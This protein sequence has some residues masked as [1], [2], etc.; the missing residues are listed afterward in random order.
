MGEGPPGVLAV[1]QGLNPPTSVLKLKFFSN[2][3][4]TKRYNFGAKGSGQSFGFFSSPPISSGHATRVTWILFFVQP[5]IGH[6]VRVAFDL[7]SATVLVVSSW[8]LLVQTQKGRGIDLTFPLSVAYHV[9]I[10][11]FLLLLSD[12]YS[13]REHAN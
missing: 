4:L 3:P 12:I 2:F 9:T 11:C 8:G 6:G 5:I 7:H 1:N 10:C 13:P